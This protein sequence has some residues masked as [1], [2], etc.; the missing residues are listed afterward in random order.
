[1][2]SAPQEQPLAWQPLPGLPT[3][4]F[5]I[6]ESKSDPCSS[7]TALI[8]TSEAVLVID[9][10]S[11]PDRAVLASQAIREIVGATDL[12]VLICLTHAHWDHIAALPLLTLPPQTPVFILA[13]ETATATLA[14]GD[15]LA[16][17]AFLFNAD[18]PTIV[19]NV[20]LLPGTARPSTTVRRHGPLLEIAPGALTLP[21]GQAL[22][23]DIVRIGGREVARAFHTPGHSPD[24][25]CLHVGDLLWVGDLFLAANPA[26]AGVP[27]WDCQALTE[28]LESVDGLL[29]AQPL[30]LCCPGHGRCLPAAKARQVIAETRIQAETLRSI[31]TLDSQ[32][33]SL[34]IEYAEDLLD[35]GLSLFTIIAGRLCT[36]SY[37]LDAMEES[38][39]AREILAVL[40]IDG[41]DATLDELR[42]FAEQFQRQHRL[43]MALPIKGIQTVGR[44]EKLF[45]TA[46]LRG[47]I[48]PTLLRRARHLLDDFM[49]TVRGIEPPTRLQTE[50]L[51]PIVADVVQTFV[52]AG[53][54]SRDLWDASDDGE[55][56]RQALTRHIVAAA[57]AV[58]LAVDMQTEPGLPAVTLDRTRIED[59]LHAILSEFAGAGATRLRIGLRA[60]EAGNEIEMRA[61]PDAQFACFTARKVRF[62]DRGIRLGQGHV[63]DAST[64]TSTV[65]VISLASPGSDSPS[66]PDGLI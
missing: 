37:H 63:T 9:P 32:R 29:E 18:C 33:V 46:R 60:T 34:L 22:R 15:R 54:S 21:S 62:L 27:G 59:A 19:V 38:Q 36:V 66:R 43:E 48:D 44:I 23:C 10:G 20:P 50:A 31:A 47:L 8:R 6:L 52:A 12:P 49:H 57:S 7:H 35:E 40:D 5:L 51:A 56:F 4:Q 42:A 14:Q 11:S 30:S 16:S 17:L 64:A 1:M 25:L 26:V 13:Q 61:V 65:L 2:S 58:R 24:S 45:D 3:G 53:E 39:T 28:S 55:A 41:L